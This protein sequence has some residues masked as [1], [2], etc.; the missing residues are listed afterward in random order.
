M[1]QKIG[2][3]R[4][5]IRQFSSFHIS[6]YAA[7]ASFF[8]ITAIFPLLMLVL[9]VLSYTPLKTETFL[10]AVSQVI[11]ETFRGIFNFIAQDV[12]QDNSVA[13]SL[14]LV[15]TLWTASKCMLGILEGLNSIA[16]VNDTRNFILKRGVCILYMLV[17]I[18]GLVL[19]LGLR[20]FGH[21]IETLLIKYLPP[22]GRVFSL[23][24]NFRGF[25]LFGA[26]AFVICMIYA[27]FPHKKMHF[28]KQ[29][30][31]A[32]FTSAAWLGFSELYSFYVDRVIRST[33]L[34][35]SLGL[36]IFAML[37]VYFC[38]WIIFIGAVINRV[39]PVAIQK[40]RK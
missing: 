19:T 3:I 20:V 2:T 10:M 27:F 11:P 34:Y 38:M 23:I 29:I 12:M 17:L 6:T 40:L 33:S 21:T 7:S 14:S 26:L 39:Y 13:L 28:L 36:I 16:D 32:V 9:S 15:T 25:A 35:G 31:G 24:M 37:W 30:P 18:L 1:K 8:T 5:Y 22:L 4:Y